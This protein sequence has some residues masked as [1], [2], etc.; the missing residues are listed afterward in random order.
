MSFSLI[1]RN[2]ELVV[3]IMKGGVAPG[4]TE[5]AW[6][7]GSGLGCGTGPPWVWCPCFVLCWKIGAQIPTRC[8]LIAGIGLGMA[9]VQR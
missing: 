7:P 8:L 5:A 9:E 6:F 3:T 4:Q 1:L 2:Q